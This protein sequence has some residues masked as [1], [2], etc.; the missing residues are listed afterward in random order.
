MANASARFS[1]FL[2]T[3]WSCQGEP[4]DDAESF[5]LEATVRK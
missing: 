3:T 2:Q 1:C 4:R 5:T